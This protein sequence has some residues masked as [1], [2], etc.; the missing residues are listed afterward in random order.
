MGRTSLLSMIFLRKPMNTSPTLS[1]MESCRILS[2]YS[3]KIPA[4]NVEKSAV[5][6]SPLS[7]VYVKCATMR[8]V[9][10]RS[11]HGKSYASNSPMGRLGSWTLW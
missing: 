9:S 11:H 3:P 5:S 4:K 2:L 6:A 8:L 1:G 10:A 7:Q